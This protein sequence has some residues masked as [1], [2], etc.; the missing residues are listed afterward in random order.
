MQSRTFDPALPYDLV[1]M[2]S[3]GLAIRSDAY[4]S[5]AYAAFGSLPTAAGIRTRFAEWRRNGSTLYFR[6]PEPGEDVTYLDAMYRPEPAPES[7]DRT[8]QHAAIVAMRGREAAALAQAQ[9]Q[10]ERAERSEQAHQRLLNRVAELGQ[11][12]REEAESRDWC[13]EYD[14]FVENFSDLGLMPL[15]REQDV[16]FTVTISFS[17][18]VTAPSDADLSD[19]VEKSEIIDRISGM[20][21]SELDYA[22]DEFEV[23]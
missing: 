12:L 20:Q 21:Y 11:A 5:D 13:E 3:G 2:Q 6:D 10:T 22:I 17:G 14:R 1:R 7:A 9:A 18:S 4:E 8:A 15:E 23:S 19:Y 16:T